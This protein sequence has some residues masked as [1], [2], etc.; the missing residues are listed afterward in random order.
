MAATCAGSATRDREAADSRQRDLYRQ[1]ADQKNLLSEKD[2]LLRAATAEALALEDEV[3]RLQARVDAFNQAAVTAAATTTGEPTVG[4]G[5]GG[6]GA[7]DDD[8]PLFPSSNAAMRH[9]RRGVDVVGE[10]MHKSGTSA[11]SRTRKSCLF[12]C[13]FVYLFVCLL[14]DIRSREAR[15]EHNRTCCIVL[16]PVH[17]PATSAAGD[18]LSFDD[19]ELDEL[20]AVSGGEP[21]GG[22]TTTP[23][24]DP[25]RA[26]ASMGGLSSNAS[27]YDDVDTVLADLQAVVEARKAERSAWLEQ[28]VGFE[29]RIAYLENAAGDEEAAVARLEAENRDLRRELDD[30][31]LKYKDA[32]VALFKSRSMERAGGGGGGGGTATGLGALSPSIL[33]S[34]FSPV[35]SATLFP[36]DSPLW[37]SHSSPL[38]ARSAVRSLVCLR[39]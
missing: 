17:D 7:G 9:L 36:S 30:V 26:D 39:V 37:F 31:L 18:D 20:A 10:L 23:A 21:G 38:R 6:I 24:S 35:K 33:A 34:P 11:V 28:R 8:D 2:E 16:V 3:E 13:L 12:V 25:R 5:S 4:S 15:L 27:L 29:A 14:L 19:G 1:L 32:K 22:R